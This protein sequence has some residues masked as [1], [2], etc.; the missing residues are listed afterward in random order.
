MNYVFM[1]F[2]S[3]HTGK[4]LGCCIVQVK[5]VHTANNR[6]KELGLM[7]KECNHAK[8]YLLDEDGFKEQGME[9]DKFYSV[10]E[11]DQMGFE[12][13]KEQI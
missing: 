9:L 11:M 6:T 3:P 5:D 10:K 7:P 2:A 8:G 4:N 12:K 1:S 13:K